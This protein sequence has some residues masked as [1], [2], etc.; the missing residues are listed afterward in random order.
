M[1]NVKSRESKVILND[2]KKYVGAVGSYIRACKTLPFS[3]L[4]L[5]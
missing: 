1:C 2:I 5:Q 3:S 4:N